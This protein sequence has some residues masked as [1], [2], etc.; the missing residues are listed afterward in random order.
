MVSDKK[1]RILMNKKFTFTTS[2]D[3]LDVMREARWYLRKSQSEL[4]R[5]AVI[6]YLERNLPKDVKE[7]IFGRR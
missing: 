5:D 7:K 2:Q 1:D 4:I 3:F 6:D